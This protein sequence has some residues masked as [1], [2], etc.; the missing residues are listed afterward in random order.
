MDLRGSNWIEQDRDSRAL[1]IWAG[2]A[3]RRVQALFRGL[4]EHS[5]D[6]K[7][8]TSMPAL[9]RDEFARLSGASELDD[10]GSAP[11]WRFVITTAIDRCLVA[12][13][14]LEWA[15]FEEKLASLSQFDP[16]LVQL[17][18][19]YIAAAVECGLDK[20]G[21]LMIPPMLREHA[22]ISRELIWAGM[23]RMV[24]LWSKDAWT[25][26]ATSSRQD[27]GVIASKLSELGL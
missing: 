19:V 7:G 8:R 4:F 12:Y 22:G 27:R 16:A 5:V 18:R 10:D 14:L 6:Q 15:R 23:G 21:R 1:W 11:G 3:I 25:R 17:R 26:E 9:L 13:P 20:H 24:E 2:V